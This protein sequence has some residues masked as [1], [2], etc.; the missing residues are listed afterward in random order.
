MRRLLPSD[1][2]PTE[3]A[4]L[5]A[6]YG[7]PAGSDPHVRVNFVSTLDGV[8]AID[9]VS[10]PLSSPLDRQ[11]FALL[12][13]L[14]DVILVGAGTA[15]TEGYGPVRAT[16]E[17][18]A[19]RARLGHDGVPPIAVVTTR[20]EL[21]LTSAFF[22]EAITRPLVFTTERA[23]EAARIAAGALAE[24]VVAGETSVD[25]RRVVA[26]LA[27]RGLPRILCE[28]GPRLFA[29]LL[30]ADAVDELCLTLAPV[31]AGGGR[32]RLTPEPRGADP[33]RFTLA[34]LIEADDGYL[35]TRYTRR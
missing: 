34:S 31:L 27:A 5:E 12:R 21:D 28:G 3:D 19:R 11:L 10:A 18:L 26:E 8:I 33:R 4:E 1:S 16:E 6:V 17:R 9:D 35:F 2:A 14:T 30:A 20:L 25:P 23:P 15:R 13:D 24:V 7:L 32:R 22:T 29:D